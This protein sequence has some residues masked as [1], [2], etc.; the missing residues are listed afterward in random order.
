M[1]PQDVP[2]PEKPGKNFT[3][4]LYPH[5]LLSPSAPTMAAE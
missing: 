4:D 3:P 1:E 2:P 5:K